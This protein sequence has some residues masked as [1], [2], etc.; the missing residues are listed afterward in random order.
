M[1][2]HLLQNVGKI[3]NMKEFVVVTIPVNLEETSV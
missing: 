2:M 3:V 1:E